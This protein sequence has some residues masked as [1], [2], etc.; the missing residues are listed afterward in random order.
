MPFDDQIFHLKCPV[1]GRET[2]EKITLHTTMIHFPLHCS[3]CEKD[4]F[5]TYI[6][7]K[8]H[9]EQMQPAAL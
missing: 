4:Y 1:C 8:T 6:N 3:Q 5:I 2:G 7:Q 9:L